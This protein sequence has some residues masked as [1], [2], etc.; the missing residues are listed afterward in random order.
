M[1]ETRFPGHL[2][3]ARREALGLSLEEVH[4]QC[5]VP[6]S[7]LEALEAGQLHLLPGKAYALGF[8]QSYCR[9]I[10]TPHEPF[11]DQ[12]Q[13]CINAAARGSRSFAWISRNTAEEGLGPRPRWM[14]ELITWG[15]ACAVVLFCWFAYSMVV[16]PLADSFRDRAEAGMV[17]VAPPSHTDENR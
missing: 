2:L 12:Y 3:R 14:E 7:A 4:E 13:T 16:K 5:H 10:G 15:T 17:E 6:P 1:K 11:T 8:I 9:A